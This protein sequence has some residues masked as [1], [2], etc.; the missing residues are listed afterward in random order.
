MKVSFLK[1]SHHY[2][3]IVPLYV[4]IDRES[5]VSKFNPFPTINALYY[6]EDL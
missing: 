3:D 2:D 4:S 6:W 5:I 1:L